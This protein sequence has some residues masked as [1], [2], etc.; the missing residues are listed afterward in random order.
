MLLWICLVCIEREI[1]EAN[2]IDR[3][4]VTSPR[5][6]SS[7]NEVLPGTSKQADLHIADMKELWSCDRKWNML[8]FFF[9]WWLGRS[10]R[11]GL[12]EISRL[13]APEIDGDA[14]Q[15]SLAL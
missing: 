14:M 11:V 12:G 4:E 15:L 7:G 13:H 10:L 6:G 5:A 8:S 1:K 9:C 3:G 2:E